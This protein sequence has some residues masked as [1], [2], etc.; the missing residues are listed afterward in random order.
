MEQER[1]RG[2]LQIKWRAL[3]NP[4]EMS[5]GEGTLKCTHFPSKPSRADR[6]GAY[7]GHDCVAEY[8]LHVR[9][10]R[11]P[12]PPYCMIVPALRAAG[13]PATACF[14]CWFHNEK[15]DQYCGIHNSCSRCRIE[16]IQ[17]SSTLRTICW[18]Y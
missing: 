14:Y 13:R 8:Q 9:T 10:R 5:D 11:D 1:R 15:M 17:K 6:I 2:T 16:K 18:V 4:R 7:A 12:G 3:R